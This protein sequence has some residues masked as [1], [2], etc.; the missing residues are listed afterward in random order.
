MRRVKGGPA[1]LFFVAFFSMSALLA[2]DGLFQESYPNRAITIVVPWGAG[3]MSD[4]IT[5]TFA[6]AA[7]KILGQPIIVEN[8]AGEGGSIGVNYALKAKP[9]GYTLGVPQTSAYIIHPHIK[10]LP[11]NPLTDAVDI[12]PITDTL[13]GIGVRSDSPWN[14]F[15]QVITY[16]RK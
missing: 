2:G 15:E 9:D 5:R 14:T 4:T 10:K 8:R 1:N 6:K 3:G 7:E 12:L 16:A 11:Y 13:M